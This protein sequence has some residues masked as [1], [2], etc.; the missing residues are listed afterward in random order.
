MEKI[1]AWGEI[2]AFL[3]ESICVHYLTT[4]DCIR[5]IHRKNQDP[6]IGAVNFLEMK[7]CVITTESDVEE[8]KAKPLGISIMEDNGHTT[9]LVCFQNHE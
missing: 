9:C 8:W 5:F 1:R 6:L 4:G 7:E 2:P 3:F